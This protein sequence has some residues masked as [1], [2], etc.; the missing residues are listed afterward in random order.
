M[1]ITEVEKQAVTRHYETKILDY[2]QS[3]P[4]IWHEKEVNQLGLTPDTIESSDPNECYQIEFLNLVQEQRESK[5]LC[6]LDTAN[7]PEAFVWR[8]YDL[9]NA[10]SGIFR[11]TVFDATG[12]ITDFLSLDLSTTAT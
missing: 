4:Y 6:Q 8:D 1:I 11:D 3:L 12:M 5:T 9:K 2:D 10:T 7:N